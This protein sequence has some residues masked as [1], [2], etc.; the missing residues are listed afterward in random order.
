[1]AVVSQ[2]EIDDAGTLQGQVNTL[3]SKVTTLENSVSTLTKERD[4]YKTKA[5]KY[6]RL[7]GAEASGDGKKEEPINGR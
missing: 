2:Q 5:E 3:N 1:M 4:D 7:P 6:A